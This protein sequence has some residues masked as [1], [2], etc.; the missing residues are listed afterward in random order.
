MTEFFD[1]FHNVL[2]RKLDRRKM[3]ILQVTSLTATADVGREGERIVMKR[4]GA[5]NSD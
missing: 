4:N 1:I 2:V 5:I 3:N